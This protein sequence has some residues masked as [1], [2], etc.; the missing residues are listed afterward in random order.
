MIHAPKKQQKRPYEAVLIGKQMGYLRRIKDMSQETL[1]KQTGVTV[2]WRGRIERGIH[3]PNIKVSRGS[4]GAL[5]PILVIAQRS[6]LSDLAKNHY[7]SKHCF[8]SHLM[9]EIY[10]ASLATDFLAARLRR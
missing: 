6:L 7:D 8:Q 10:N 2:G 1:A 3:L 9:I 5:Q 4:S